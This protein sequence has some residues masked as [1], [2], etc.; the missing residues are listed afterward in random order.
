MVEALAVELQRSFVGLMGPG[1]DLDERR[2][3]CAVL[4]HEGMNL[5]GAQLKRHLMER[6]HACKRFR[7]V[8]QDQHKEIITRRRGGAELYYLLRAFAPPRESYF[9]LNRIAFS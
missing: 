1:D 7:D 9:L 3:S 2:F 5:A 8:S 4:A 6:P